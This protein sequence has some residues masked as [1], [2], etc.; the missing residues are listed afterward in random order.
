VSVVSLRLICP[1]CSAILEHELVTGQEMK[2]S[3]CPNCQYLGMRFDWIQVCG[4]EAYGR[5]MFEFERRLR[6]VERK[7]GEGDPSDGNRLTI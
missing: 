5:M 4:N 2:D 3:I 7:V 6:L 1:R